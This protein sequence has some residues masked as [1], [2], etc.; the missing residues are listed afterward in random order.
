MITRIIQHFN[1]LPVMM[2]HVKQSGA[3]MPLITSHWNTP[4]RPA[5]DTGF[6]QALADA[7]GYY[8]TVQ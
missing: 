5:N 1:G 4:C 7:A 2:F 8:D 6:E 3:R